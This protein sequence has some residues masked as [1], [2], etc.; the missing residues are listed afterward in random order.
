MIRRV[1]IVASAVSL[2]L[3][4][5]ISGSWF[6][7]YRTAEQISLQRN[8]TGGRGGMITTYECRLAHGGAC[9]SYSV[10][11]SRQPADLQIVHHRWSHGRVESSEYPVVD[12]SV[13]MRRLLSHDGIRT[14]DY[15]AIGFQYLHYRRIAPGFPPRLSE[16]QRLTLP[17]WALW[18]STALAPAWMGVR[19]LPRRHVHRSGMCVKCGYDLR[20]STERCPECG[21]TIRRN[22]EFHA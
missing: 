14:T 4:M 15:G 10:S 3:C 13:L 11:L 17:M 6:M 9:F 12:M 19:L 22:R 21:T 2:L 1:F 18:I 7:T 5:A 8:F 16:G 20:A